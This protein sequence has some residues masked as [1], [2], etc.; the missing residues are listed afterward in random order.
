MKGNLRHIIISYFLMFL[1]QAPALLQLEHI[2]DNDHGIVYRQDTA[3]IHNVSTT[4]CGSLHKNLNY[5]YWVEHPVFHFEQAF[6]YFN[7]DQ[8]VPDRIY[9]FNIKYYQLR[10]PP[11]A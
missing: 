1:I 7:I 11:C 6:L 10:A 5:I 4:H 9:L 8:L 3:E 2:F